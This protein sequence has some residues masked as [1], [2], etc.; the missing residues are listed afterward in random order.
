[1]AFERWS[2]SGKGGRRKTAASGRL[3]SRY[4][5]TRLVSPLW[6]APTLGTGLA[7]TSACAVRPRPLEH[8]VREQPDA[9]GTVPYVHAR[10]GQPDTTS[11]AQLSARS[12]LEAS[13]SRSHANEV[14][15]ALSGR[16]R[17]AP[18]G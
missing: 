13:R 16:G 18:H 15:L 10:K 12:R 5:T 2:T 14:A 7:S 1:M 17:S 11:G 4:R 8:G 6:P 9:N 3:E